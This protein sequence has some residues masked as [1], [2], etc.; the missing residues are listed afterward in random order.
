MPEEKLIIG[1][2]A[3]GFHHAGTGFNAG[4]RN[5]IF[6]EIQKMIRKRVL[7]EEKIA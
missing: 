5:T 3:G 6:N 2:I 4:C 7:P 1:A